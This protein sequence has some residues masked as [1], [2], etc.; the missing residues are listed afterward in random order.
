MKDSQPIP[1]D[2]TGGWTYFDFPKHRF[3][4]GRW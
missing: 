1:I 3:L 4:P 2:L